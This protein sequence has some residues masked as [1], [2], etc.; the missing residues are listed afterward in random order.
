MF[1][2]VYCYLVLNINKEIEIDKQTIV[3]VK[4]K[5][6]INFAEPSAEGQLW[7]WI[8]SQNGLSLKH[9]YLYG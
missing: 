5:M 2:C 8:C 1:Y 4:V 3:P 7:H 6:M 9:P